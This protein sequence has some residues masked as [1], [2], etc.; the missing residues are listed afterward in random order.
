MQNINMGQHAAALSKFEA[1]VR[2]KRDQYVLQLCFMESCA[3]R[4]SQKAKYYYKLLT[5]A[6]QTRFQQMCI[7]NKVPFQD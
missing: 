5:P 6:Q 3:A 2:G 1:S 4:N 7:R